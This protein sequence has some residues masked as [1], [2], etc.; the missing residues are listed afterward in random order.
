MLF[1]FLGFLLHLFFLFFN[2]EFFNLFWVVLFPNLLIKR[3]YC[4]W[5]IV[6]WCRVIIWKKLFLFLVFLGI[7]F[8]YLLNIL[9]QGFF[10]CSLLFCLFLCFCHNMRFTNFYWFNFTIFF[11]IIFFFLWPCDILIILICNTDIL[12]IFIGCEL[13]NICI[14]IIFRLFLLLFLF[15]YLSSSIFQSFMLQFFPILFT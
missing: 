11:I 7:Q 2:F 10:S 5:F 3:L 6:W 14:F 13:I 15:H 4:S 8:L 9:I 1:E 12:N